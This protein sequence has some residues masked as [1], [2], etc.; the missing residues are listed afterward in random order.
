[1]QPIRV[2]TGLVRE[3]RKIKHVAPVYPPVAVA[4]HAEA[5]VTLEA[6]IDEG[7]R[8]VD[9]TVLQGDSLFDNAALEA[10]RQWAYSPT[11]VDGVPVPIIMTVTVHFQ[12]TPG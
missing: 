4:A 2:G 9:V 3:P 8:V 6:S 11:L 5:S 10:V 12:L 7:G 1:L